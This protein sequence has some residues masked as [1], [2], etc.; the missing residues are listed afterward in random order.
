MGNMTKVTVRRK[1]A[2]YRMR[3]AVGQMEGGPKFGR[4]KR[5][6]FGIFAPAC[7]GPGAACLFCAGG[8]LGRRCSIVEEPSA[9]NV[10]SA[11]GRTRIGVSEAAEVPFFAGVSGAGKTGA[12]FPQA[13]EAFPAKARVRLLR[14]RIPGMRQG[15]MRR[16]ARRSCLRCGGRSVERKMRARGSFDR[17]RKEACMMAFARRGRKSGRKLL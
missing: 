3:C 14:R 1:Q 7:C 9:D 12:D 5:Q 15:R 10:F 8:R 6:V 17:G 2:S 4:G 16:K 11:D 13:A